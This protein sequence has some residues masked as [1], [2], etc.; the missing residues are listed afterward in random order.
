[1]RRHKQEKTTFIE[2][3][4]SSHINTRARDSGTDIGVI[5]KSSR[6]RQTEIDALQSPIIMPNDH[7]VADQRPSL[8]H[9]LCNRCGH[10]VHRRGFSPDV[11]NRDGIRHICKTCD[12]EHK[13]RLYEYERFVSLKSRVNR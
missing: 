13:R 11:R 9:F 3:G 2:L 6:A 7:V 1:M 8:E 4:G 12:A 5:Q 10:Y